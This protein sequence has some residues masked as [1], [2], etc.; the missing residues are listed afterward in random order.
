MPTIFISQGGS[1]T[2]KFTKFNFRMGF[3]KMTDNL[4]TIC[5]VIVIFNFLD[6]LEKHP[7]D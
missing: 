7:S 5:S 6:L 2:I 4:G 3:T 1:T